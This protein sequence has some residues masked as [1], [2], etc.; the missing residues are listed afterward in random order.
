MQPDAH[1]GHPRLPL[2]RDPAPQRHP[3]GLGLDAFDD[4]AD[5]SATLSGGDRLAPSP[6]HWRGNETA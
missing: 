1:P 6:R 4:E 2:E 3:P 5:P